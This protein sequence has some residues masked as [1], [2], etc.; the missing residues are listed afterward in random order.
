MLQTDCIAAIIIIVGIKSIE[1]NQ[2]FESE[3]EGNCQLFTAYV[4]RVAHSLLRRGH[5]CN[6]INHG[7]GDYTKV[8]FAL[9]KTRRLKR[10]LYKTAILS[11][12]K[13]ESLVKR[14]LLSDVEGSL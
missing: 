10:T 2:C 12:N 14:S 8:T 5:G 9:R 7:Q 6:Q 3:I 1:G 13:Y 4:S 11:S